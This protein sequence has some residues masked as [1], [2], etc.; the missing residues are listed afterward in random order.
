MVASAIR[1]N[2]DMEEVRDRKRAYDN[3]FVAW[4]THVRR[5]LFVI[6]DVMGQGKQT[7]IEQDFEDSLIAAM[8]DVDRCITQAYDKRAAGEDG[9][10]VLNACNMTALHQFVLDCGSSFVNE[11]DKL[12]RLTFNPLGS[13]FEE[14]LQLAQKRITKGCTHAANAPVP[15]APETP[16][17]VP[18]PQPTEARPPAEATT[19]PSLAPVQATTP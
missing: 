3:A 10:A 14:G 19:A 6:R 9:I 15:P 16:L 12:N 18:P 2:A 8:A 5:N 17:A 11:L 1:R 13:S 7:K 4:N